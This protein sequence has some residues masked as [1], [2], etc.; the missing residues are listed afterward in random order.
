MWQAAAAI[1]KWQIKNAI[2]QSNVQNLLTNYCPMRPFPVKIIFWKLLKMK[3]YQTND[4][5]KK[6]DSIEHF[7]VT[8]IINQAK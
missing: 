4:N 3:R 1:G 6:W 7:D 2:T 8:K 5:K